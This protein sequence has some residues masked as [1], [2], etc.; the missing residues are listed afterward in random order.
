MLARRAAETADIG[1]RAAGMLLGVKRQPTPTPDHVHWAT[2]P[3]LWSS[4][5][6]NGRFT[7]RYLEEGY[8]LG[9]R[10]LMAPPSVDWVAPS[11]V[12]GKLGCRLAESKPL[13]KKGP[14]SGFSFVN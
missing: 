5:H 12:A 9:Q 10:P 6:V 1:D 11:E 8:C 3:F 2:G 7:L 4:I 13:P 14:L